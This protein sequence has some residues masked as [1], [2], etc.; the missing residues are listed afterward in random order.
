[1]E[2]AEHELLEEDERHIG[3]SRI[4]TRLS[5][6]MKIMGLIYMHIGFYR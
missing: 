2:R 1:M 4:L 5:E 6:L 3:E